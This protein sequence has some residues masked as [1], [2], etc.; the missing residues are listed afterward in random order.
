[1]VHIF[2]I[3]TTVL[4]RHGRNPALWD[5]PCFRESGRDHR[6]TEHGQSYFQMKCTDHMLEWHWS[7]TRLGE[8][9]VKR[10][11][12]VPGGT[13]VRERPRLDHSSCNPCEKLEIFHEVLFK[14]MDLLIFTVIWVWFGF[15]RCAPWTWPMTTGYSGFWLI[16]SK[17]NFLSHIKNNFQNYVSWGKEVTGTPP[18]PSF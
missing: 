1:M 11:V 5:S 8:R 9:L 18:H 10:C 17:T 7:K 15:L 2:K 14:K 12:L 3:I 13:D 6:D 16:N 4:W